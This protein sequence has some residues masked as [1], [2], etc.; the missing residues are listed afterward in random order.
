MFKGES[1]SLNLS[2]CVALVLFKALRQQYFAD[3][4]HWKCGHLDLTVEQSTV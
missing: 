3:E 1:R 2:N 4:I